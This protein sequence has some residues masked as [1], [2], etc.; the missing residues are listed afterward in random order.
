MKLGKL[1][2]CLLMLLS[3][4]FI[5]NS[6]FKA[7][8][9]ITEVKDVKT[10]ELIGPATHYQAS[11]S[12]YYKGEVKP[13]NLVTH[14]TNWIELDNSI[15]AS[16]VRVVSYSKGT[17]YNWKGGRPTELAKAFE[18]EHPGWL[19]LG[20]VNGDFFHI[21][22]N[23]EPCSTFMQEGEFFKSNQLYF[24]GCLGFFEDGR[25][26]YGTADTSNCEYLERLN[27]EGKYDII[28]EI[29]VVDKAPS[30]TGI[31]LLTRFALT[32]APYKDVSTVGTFSYDLTGY[33][34]VKVE[35]STERLD[36]ETK[37]VYV[38][39]VVKEI[40]NNV[41]SLT[42]NDAESLSYLV[43]KDSSLDSLAVGDNVRCQAELK[44]SWVGVTN[45]TGVYGHILNNGVIQD[46]AGNGD[47]YVTANK[48]RTV[49]GFKA[50]G[51]PVLMTIDLKSFGA[52]YLECAEYLQRVGCVNGYLFDGGGSSLM[53]VRNSNNEFEIVNVPSDGSERRD[54]NAVLLVM[55]DPGFNVTTSSV[56]PFSA[57]INLKVTNNEAFKDVSNIKVTVN[58]ET[59]DY[60]EGVTFKNLDEKTTYNVKVNYDIKV[61]GKVKAGQVVG[62]FTTGTISNVNPGLK[63]VSS[64]KNTITVSRDLTLPNASMIS[65]VIVHIGDSTF[66]M[67][68]KGELVCD[69]LID[70]TEYSIYFTYDVVDSETGKSVNVSTIDSAIKYST[71]SY[72]PPVIEQ[73]IL[74]DDTK[75]G[76]SITYKYTDSDR[77]VTKAYI[78]VDGVETLVLKGRN[79]TV[80]VDFDKNKSHTIKLV[81]EYA[82]DDK[83][84][85]VESETIEYQAP[86]PTPT[87]SEPSETPKK[88]CGKK[89]AE[90]V[91]SLI[92]ISTILAFILRKRH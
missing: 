87:P 82:K 3:F 2:L 26:I 79:L 51:T 83:S 30:E 52:T 60:T 23:C 25:F 92:S 55:K 19:V 43:A 85:V 15:D 62:S 38:K 57:S 80:D 46:H 56:G 86:T 72:N 90:L 14:L 50:D 66:N 6:S 35:Y 67:G 36:R 71:L 91:I 54:A 48:N 5:F 33:K 28:D 22:D 63:V 89:S 13:S 44:G 68:T 58:G 10:R 21:D 47:D 70:D 73:F 78:S 59:K 76:L 12:S 20:G 74:S 40:V 24:E 7:A 49:M 17:A 88:K 27:A 77:V 64:T 61:D 45:I 31:S 69:G 75:N 9:T 65:N 53:F 32:T 37:R 4:S 41:S 42:L 39:G 16:S 8:S 18:A 1:I 29:K 81:L 84:F 11:I 34:I